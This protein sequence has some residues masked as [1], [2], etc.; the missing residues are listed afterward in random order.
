MHVFTRIRTWLARERRANFGCA[1]RRDQCSA[2]SK[3]RRQETRA[4][5][6]GRETRDLEWAS[7]RGGGR[8]MSKSTSTVIGETE[9]DAGIR[10]ELARGAQVAG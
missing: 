1:H 4:A 8:A 3:S 10:E 6:R 7:K 2:L 9:G 5:L